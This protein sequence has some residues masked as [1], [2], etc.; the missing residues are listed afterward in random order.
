MCSNRID[1]FP[2]KS[3]YVITEREKQRLRRYTTMKKDELKRDYDRFEELKKAY[4]EAKNTDDENG[5]KTA[6]AAYKELLDSVHEKGEEYCFMS[7]LYNEM[8]ERGNKCIDI[9]EPYQYEDAGKLIGRLKD[10]GFECFTFSSTWSG[11]L[12]TAWEFTQSGCTMDGM[13]EISGS[14]KAIMSDDYEKVHAFL[15]KLN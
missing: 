13:V 6:K 1:I 15:F 9:S 11:A 3:E 14:S 7:R 12:E 4:D 2:E 5:M 8:R 10:F